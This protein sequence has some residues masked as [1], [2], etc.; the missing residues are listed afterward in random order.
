MI[1]MA[2]QAQ[3]NITYMKH[4]SMK[5]I[6]GGEEI[7]R[8]DAE[9]ESQNAPSGTCIRG[10]DPKTGRRAPEDSMNNV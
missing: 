7:A 10:C 5:T 6:L 1:D 4:E 9:G 3:S 8:T 2:I